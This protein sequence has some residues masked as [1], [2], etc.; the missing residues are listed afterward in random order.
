MSNN[1]KSTISKGLNTKDKQSLNITDKSLINNNNTDTI[2]S[3][4]NLWRNI[5][6]SYFTDNIKHMFNSFMQS[7]NFSMCSTSHN[8][9]LIRDRFKISQ[10]ILV[11]Q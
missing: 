8:I 5:F 2:N 3:K 11:N 9:N 6:Y 1:K 4:S 7:S 10:I